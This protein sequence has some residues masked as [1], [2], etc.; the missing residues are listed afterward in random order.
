MPT[1]DGQEN[2]DGVS[3]LDDLINSDDEDYENGDEKFDED[4][5]GINI[6]SDDDNSKD[7]S[8]CVENGS[9]DLRKKSENIETVPTFPEVRK[10]LFTID[11][12]IGTNS[13]ENRNK[14]KS[15]EDNDDARDSCKKKK[16]DIFDKIPSPP[17]KII[18]LK[19]QTPTSLQ[20]SLASAG[21]YGTG[22]MRVPSHGIPSNFLSMPA[23]GS[24]GAFSHVHGIQSPPELFLRPPGM[25]HHSSTLT[26]F[27][28][29]DWSH[30][31]SSVTL[32]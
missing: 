5:S 1:K 11:S 29:A 7:S 12:I 31:Q 27:N 21:L 24:M 14:R 4:D 23:Y 8:S 22:F 32:R 6:C 10:R 17:P 26:S 25:A 15:T 30:R 16:F 3:S 2:L 20:L 28:D 13:D 9:H 19:G 18:D